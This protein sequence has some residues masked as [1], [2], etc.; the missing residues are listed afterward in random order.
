MS[1]FKPY[2]FLFTT[3][4]LNKSLYKLFKSANLTV[5]LIRL[6]T[7]WSVSSVRGLNCGP[8]KWQREDSRCFRNQGKEKGSLLYLLTTPRWV[9]RRKERRILSPDCRYYYKHGETQWIYDLMCINSCGLSDT[10][11]KKQQ[12]NKENSILQRIDGLNKGYFCGKIVHH[13]LPDHKHKTK[14]Q[15]ITDTHTKTSRKSLLTFSWVR[16]SR[17]WTEWLKMNKRTSGFLGSLAEKL[18]LFTIS[19]L[20]EQLHLIRITEDP[21]ATETN[22]RILG[23]E[24]ILVSNKICLKWKQKDSYASQTELFSFLLCIPVQVLQKSLH[25]KQRKTMAFLFSNN[26]QTLTVPTSKRSCIELSS[27]RNTALTKKSPP[28]SS[29]FCYYYETKTKSL[30]IIILQCC[31]INRYGRI[32]NFLTSVSLDLCSTALQLKYT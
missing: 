11:W 22:S 3:K 32:S 5:L 26:L 18:G 24:Q 2:L 7:V 29:L 6:G 31:A 27:A 19:L 10:S 4:W 12:K 25:V 21:A 9:W 30:Q 8:K 1:S 28:K 16:V 20:C 13:L 14:T 23:V 15:Q 17:F